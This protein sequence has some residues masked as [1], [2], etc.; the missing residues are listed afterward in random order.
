MGERTSEAPHDFSSV[1]PGGH[2]C[3][4]Y[5]KEE[6]K[7]LAVAHFIHDG[8]VRGERCIYWGHPAGY[9]AVLS[10]LEAEGT[11]TT[12]LRQRRHLLFADVSRPA[13]KGFDIEAQTAAIRTAIAEARADG[14]TG[15][16]VV[17]DPDHHARA[18]LNREQ[19]ALLESSLSEIYT[20][21]HATG[22]CT[23]DQRVTDPSS[24]EIALATHESAIVAGRLC[25]NP[26]FTSKNSAHGAPTGA[27]RAASMA[28]NILSTTLARDLLEAES[29]ALIVE[30]SRSGRR[31]AAYRAHIAAL[32][33]AI[34]ARDRLIIT[35][36][37]WLS[38]PLP[39]MCSHLADLARDS[40]FSACQDTLET[41]SEHLA[42]V[43]RLSRG[44]DEIASFL[45]MQVVLRPEK[46]DIVDLARAAIAELKE[47]QALAQIEV[48]FEG[49]TSIVGTWDRLRITHLFHSLIITAR[50]QGYDTRVSLRLDDLLEFV[51]IRLEFTLPHAPSISDS[52]ER[53]RMVAYSSSDESD[54]ERLAVQL[55]PARETVRMMGG[56]LGI[57]TWADARVI[58]TLDLPKSAPAN[59]AELESYG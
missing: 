34:E 12:T 24:F 48:S 16:R 31:D 2:V 44:L 49:A 5:A 41:C 36:A 47:D 54:Y 3:L 38:R 18:S 32:T 59:P 23:F 53:I 20:Q 15:L 51:R 26:Y 25:P 21:A 14:F 1:K 57:S 27:E 13:S 22:L 9:A 7:H 43:T 29:A 11:S 10:R 6:E 17:G 58:F 8:L 35:T 52:G 46:L 28:A 39:A 30:T 56:T 55:W 45:Q 4:P 37:R 42:A 40:R 19:L 50:D 33:R